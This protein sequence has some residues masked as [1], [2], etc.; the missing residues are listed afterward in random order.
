MRNAQGLPDAEPGNH[1]ESEQHH[2]ARGD[3]MS[4]RTAANYQPDN[5]RAGLDS[6]ADDTSPGC[7]IKKSADR[8]HGQHSDQKPAFAADLSEHEWNQGEGNNQFRKSREMIAVHVWAER[9]SSEVHLADP[10]KLAVKRKML[11]DAENGDK[12]SENHHKPGETAK[13]FNGPECLRRHENNQNVGDQE[14]QLH[15][16]VV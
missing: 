12:K 5:D 9:D 8:N 14:L 3:E 10:V 6:K 11:K 15:R 1:Q 2:C 7:G 13:V 4:P 16:R